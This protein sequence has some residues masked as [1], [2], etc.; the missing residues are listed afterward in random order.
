MRQPEAPGDYNYSHFR[1]R[2]ITDEV[3]GFLGARGIRPGEPAPDFELPRAGGGTV[4][5]V[6]LRDR[7]VLLHFGSYT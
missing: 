2:H 6:D 5:L 4:R 1:R 7:P 3:V